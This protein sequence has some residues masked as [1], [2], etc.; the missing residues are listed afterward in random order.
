MKSKTRQTS[1]NLATG[2]AIHILSGMKAKFTAIVRAEEDMFVAFNP[3]LDISSQGDSRTTA[4]ENL[5]EAVNLFLE[6]APLQEIEG[7]LSVDSWIT[8]FEAEY[9]PA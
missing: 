7:R 6:T 3:E 4:L 5:Q 1:R 8:Q 9:V 2:G